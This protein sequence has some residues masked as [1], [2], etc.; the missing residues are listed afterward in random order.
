M[1]RVVEGPCDVDFRPLI[2]VGL[3]LAGIAA[4]FVALAWM[5]RR[6]WVDTSKERVRRG[7]GHAMLGVQEFVEPSVEYI[8]QAENTEQ[9]EE[10]DAEP[11]EG[12][13]EAILAD[14]AA[15]LGRDPI[16]AEEVRRHLASAHRAGLDWCELFDCTVRDELASR[17]YRA[18]SIPPD[19]KVAPRE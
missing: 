15:S 14:L 10:E 6:G 7:A 3:L 19:W 13:P 17:P 4:S 9:A 8:L 12:G 18:P 16:D 5:R 1:D 11:S 2:P